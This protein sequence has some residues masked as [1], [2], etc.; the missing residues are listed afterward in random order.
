M[1]RLHLI[2]LEHVSSS[3]QRRLVTGLITC[4]LATTALVAGTPTPASAAPAPIGPRAFAMHFLDTSHRY[5][6]MP[7]KSAR[8]WDMGVTWA[9]LQPDGPSWDS[10]ALARL[11]NIVH[12]F[13]RHGVQPLIVLGMTPGWA[14]ASCSHD[15]WPAT[16]CGPKLTGTRSPWANYVRA[17]AKRYHGVFFETWNEPNLKNGWNDTTGKLARM[18][19]TAYTVIHGART[20]DR[21]VSPTVAV[22]AGHPYRWLN[23][24]FHSTGGK[25]FDVFG[26]HLYP[27][28]HS[29]RYGYGPE[30][31]IGEFQKLRALLRRNHL[32]GKQMWDTEANVGRYQYR[33]STSRTFTGMAGA[34]MVARTYALQL[35]SG[36][37]RIFWY[38]ADDR[39]WGGTWM[40]RSD[41]YSLTDAGRAERVMHNLLVRAPP[42]GCSHYRTHWTCK[43]H[44]RSGKN[45][46]AKWTT[47]GAWYVHAPRHSTRVYNVL[48]GSVATHGGATVKVTSRPRFIVGSFSL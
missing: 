10:A 38:A 30:W 3:L 39:G 32:G 22:T 27:S 1:S 8:V 37:K 28:D 4:L 48:G 23:T 47:R 45:M 17:L 34:A 42:Y 31:S 41:F 18:Q 13:V 16:T 6:V 29:A 25:R 5:P 46:L 12:M 19:S 36:V 9:D 26:A 11:D 7:F 2:G 40:E 44:L 24:F 15:G 35:A 20:A 21:L 43:F 14:R 33:R